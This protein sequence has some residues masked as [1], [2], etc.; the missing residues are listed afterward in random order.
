MLIGNYSVLSKH[1]GRD[2]AGGATGLGCNRGDWSKSSLRRAAYSGAD[3]DPKSAVPEGCL[4]PYSWVIPLNAGGMSSHGVVVG[5]GT[6]AGTLAG[7]RW[8][9]AALTGFGEVENTTRLSL[10]VGMSADLDGEG[11]ISAAVLIGDAQLT[12]DLTGEGTFTAT[13]GAL[14]HLA[15]DLDGT[16]D[17]S[18]SELTALAHMVANVSPFTTLSPENLAAS[19]WN[20]LA[21]SHDSSG[22]MGEK[23]NAAGTAGDPWT[24]ALPDV[25]AD[26]TAGYIIGLIAA[27][28]RNKT[29][30]DPDT[31]VMTVYAENGVDVLFTAD[32]FEDAAGTQPYDGQGVNRRERLA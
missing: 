8:M 32:I 31:G 25:Y 14:G 29:V 1:P 12:A 27:L 2:I 22:S 13:L 9:T 28:L 15:A 5:T 21:A 26:G 4:P 24:A 30:T 3:W 20:A 23:L 10:I 19:V 6:L 7:G 17:L 18:T 11:L 16:C